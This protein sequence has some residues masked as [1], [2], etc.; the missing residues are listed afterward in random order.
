MAEQIGYIEVKASINTR[1]YDAGKKKIEQGNKDL[2]SSSDKT[3][4]KFS[5]AWTGA[6]AGVAASIASK[7]ASAVSGAVGDMTELYDASIKFP[8][9][10]TTMGATSEFASEAFQSL[11]TYADETIY[12]LDEMTKTFGS[13]YGIT[14]KNT[15]ALV[16][17]LG[18]ISTLAANSA[19]AM[20]SWSLQLTQMVA[21]PTVAWQDFRILLEQNPAAI[22][23]I[24]EA[25]GKST[26]QLIKDVQDGA[27][28]TGKFLKAMQK[29]G[30]SKDLQ[31]A[32]TA[33]DTFGNSIGQLEASIASAG[34]KF[35]DIFGTGIISTIN[36][37]SVAFDT[38]STIIASMIEDLKPLLD[39]ITKNKQVM[40]ALKITLMIIGAVLLG[41][42]MAGISAVIV[43]VT[44]LTATVE[45]L[46]G[47]F[48]WLMNTA[49]M[50]WGAI[51]KWGSDTWG[52]IKKVFSVVGRWFGDVF[53]GAWKA[54]KN[55]FSGIKPYFK[56]IWNSIV[57]VFGNI[58]VA[59]GNAIGG[60]FKG[61]INGII[62]FVESTVN[63]VIKSINSVAEGIDEALPGDQSGWRVPEVKLPRLAKG[64]IVKSQPGGILANIG[65]GRYDEAVVPLNDKFYDAL[66]KGGGSNESTINVTVNGVFATSKQEQRKVA[67][68][69]AARIKEVQ[70]SKAI[71]GATI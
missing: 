13:L 37:L 60:A 4:K 56:G 18:G 57:G 27:V 66:S 29:V 33:S 26:S 40:D 17:A 1:D 71:K 43:A 52:T 20:Q 22:A 58:G 6:I 59:I 12:S 68:Q 35:L 21:K 7:L 8:K 10:L 39:Y 46:I 41:A 24:A 5:A 36:G 3:S 61:V 14:G 45:A 49:I 16:T 55:A 23:K 32:A 25:M 48:T 70:T 44:I 62:K 53:S 34:A 11:K 28:E 42:V 31:K 69:I 19:Q 38:V 50:V 51:A 65:E 67:E 15:G 30:N 54:I 9:V 64:G 47:V 63:G 2:E